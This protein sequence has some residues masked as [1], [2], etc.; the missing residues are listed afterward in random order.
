MQSILGSFVHELYPNAPIYG[1][2]VGR[3]LNGVQ[4]QGGSSVLK[5]QKQYLF[6]FLLFLF[7][8]AFPFPAAW[9]YFAEERVTAR[10]AFLVDANSGQVLYQREADLSL[11][12][13]STTK[14]LTAI[15]ALESGRR[16]TELLRVTKSA[17]R[18]PSSKLNLRVGQ[19]MSIHDLLYG[20][21]LTSANDAGIVLAEGLAGSVARF[22]ELMNLKAREIGAINSRFVNPHGLTAPEHYSTAKDMALI[23][24]YA[25]KNPEFRE[26]IQTKTGSVSFI[27][28]GKTRKMRRISVRSH[29][30]LLWNFDGAIGG[31]TGYTFAAQKCFVGGVSR[32]GTTLIVSVMGSRDLWGDVRRLLEHGL[33]NHETLKITAPVAPVFANGKLLVRQPKASP[34]ILTSEEETRIQS[35]DGYVLQ[36]ASFRERER[37][38]NLQKWILEGGYQAFLE[39][40]ALNNG[41]TTYR[42]RIGPYLQLIQAQEAAR[43]IEQKSGYRAI[44]LPASPVNESAERPS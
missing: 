36:I 6:L 18:V 29:N 23:F 31:K 21:L 3:I 38:E 20:L 34:S 2:R 9:S 15:V 30:R 11:S 24:S 37:A 1:I 33:D 40:A 4:P 32:N 17:T 44:I 12:P 19:S 26:I 27:S 7:L 14:I 42:V 25:M 43:E 16:P 5:G 10:A 8:I 22:G 41:E 28:S 13:A 35:T 39:R